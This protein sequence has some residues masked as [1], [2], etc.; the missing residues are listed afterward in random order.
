L[1]TGSYLKEKKRKKLKEGGRERKKEGED[2]KGGGRSEDGIKL[3]L[4]CYGGGDNYQ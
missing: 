2:L 1:Q 3:V 4:T